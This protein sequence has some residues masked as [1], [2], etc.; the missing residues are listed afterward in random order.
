MRKVFVVSVLLFAALNTSAQHRKTTKPKAK[1]TPTPTTKAH[2][3]QY[4]PC[5]VFYKDIDDFVSDLRKGWRLVG[6]TKTDHIWYDS[7][8]QR[9]GDNGILKTWIKEMHL[10]T[11]LKYALVLYELN[12]K[13]DELRVVSVT[14]YDKDG[15]VIESRQYND[16]AWSDA[17]PE[18]IGEEILK[19]AC[20]KP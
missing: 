4:T 2:W 10:N 7:D 6:Q 17:V 11:D 9:C 20:R 8:R 19:I 15:H 13:T 18:S 5:G 14:E 1:S 12:C 3:E 16:P